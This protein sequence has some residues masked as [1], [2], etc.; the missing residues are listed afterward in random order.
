[1]RI[2]VCIKQIAHTYARTGM[3]PGRHY[4][5]PED[6]VFRINPHDELAVGMAVAATSMSKERTV[7]L[8]T[9]GPI[10]AEEELVRCMAMGAD[11]LVQI[12]MDGRMD[13]W[14]KSAFLARAISDLGAD[15][16]LCGNA[17]L[18]TRNGQVGALLAHHLGASYVSNVRD[19]ALTADKGTLQVKRNAGRGVRELVSCPLPAVLGV[20]L[21]AVA[22]PIPAFREKKRWRPLP[23]RK[24]TYDQDS[25][26]PKCVRLRT[27]PPRPRPKI[28]P[29]PDSH[30]GAHD[31]T[32]QLLSGSRVEKRGEILT[33]SPESQVEGIIAFLKQ[34]D[35]LKIGKKRDGG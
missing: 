35:L 29:P 8:L 13:P 9:L 4:L 16:V 31:R 28:V 7:T 25:V 33:G 32:L 24:L 19:L 27:Y 20:D 21:G 12:D 18:D 11:R 2:I 10:L 26:Q 6:A 34:H 23:V 15:L 30:L 1:M 22:P 14:Q 5:A 17:S 3:D